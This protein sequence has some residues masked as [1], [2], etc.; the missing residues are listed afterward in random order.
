MAVRAVGVGTS[1]FLAELQEF[2]LREDAPPARQRVLKAR[3][4]REAVR[5]DTSVFRWLVAH[6]VRALV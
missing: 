5:L 1:S 4:G 6:R 3:G 2:E